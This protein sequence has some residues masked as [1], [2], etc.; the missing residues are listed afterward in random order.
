M[1]LC[2]FYYKVS[3]F[4]RQVP[5]LSSLSSRVEDTLTLCFVKSTYVL[6]HHGQMLGGGCVGVVHCGSTNKPFEFGFGGRC[7]GS[8]VVP[9]G[10]AFKMISLIARYVAAHLGRSIIPAPPTIEP[11]AALLPPFQ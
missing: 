3:N 10:P 4:L 7:V 5:V 6:L 8:I 1:N 11:F 9:P 2:L